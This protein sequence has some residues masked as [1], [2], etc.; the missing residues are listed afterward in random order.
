MGTRRSI[1]RQTHVQPA[2]SVVW[3]AGIT[4]SAQ[5]GPL[6]RQPSR[7][8]LMCI[9][10]NV[11]GSAKMTFAVTAGKGMLNGVRRAAAVGVTVIAL[12]WLGACAPRSGVVA[13]HHGASYSFG[14]WM[15]PLGVA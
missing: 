2:S 6:R 8:Y 5:W 1:T 9:R 15:G 7:S 10:N 12:M 14:H 11:L 4:R 3:P 13:H